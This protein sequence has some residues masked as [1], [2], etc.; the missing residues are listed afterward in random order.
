LPGYDRIYVRFWARFATDYHY[1]HHM[2][3]IDAS[4]AGNKWAALG[5]RVVVRAGRTTVCRPGVF[6]VDNIAARCVELYACQ[7]LR[8]TS[9][10]DVCEL[11]QSPA[12]LQRLRDQGFALH[13]WSRMLLGCE[14][15]HVSRGAGA[16]REMD[17]RGGACRCQYRQRGEQRANAFIDGQQ[18]GQWSG[19]RFRMTRPED[20]LARPLALRH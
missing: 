8:V 6:G 17:L 7:N 20:Q 19:I 16:T 2:V 5:P 14:R 12:D 10:R 9:G 11:R 18:V 13:E 3:F 4:E 1:L 15:H